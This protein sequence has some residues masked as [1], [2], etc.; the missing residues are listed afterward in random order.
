M[1]IHGL[2]KNIYK[3]YAWARTQECLDAYRVKYETGVG[4]WEALRAEG[5]SVAKCAEFC[6]ISRAT[7]FRR[8][9]VLRAL[10]EGVLPPSKAPKRRNKPQWG[11]A[12]IQ[13]VLEVRRANKTYGKDKIAVILVRDKGCKISASTVGR[14]LLFL[15]KKGRI[16]RSYSA[17][18][19]RA[20]NFSK[21]HAK[22]WTYKN[23]KDLALGERVQIDHMSVTKNGVTA[24]HFQAWE[25]HSKHIF[26]QV[27]SNATARSAKRFLQELIEITPYKIISIQVDGGS[28]FMA[29]FEAA[30]ENLAIPLEV[31]P[32]SRPTYNGGVERGNRTF[33]EEFYACRDLLA[34][35]I[36][37][38][39]VELK[40]AVEKYNA[41]RPHH[42]LKGKTPF[43]YLRIIQAEVS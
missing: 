39:R 28:E 27:Y 33:R 14:I 20:R 40:K 9:Q 12:Q 38:I 6:G 22:R 32:P 16:T 29:D 26:A 4:R 25:R 21:G 24:K 37:A 3:L 18:Q 43:E 10:A 1:Q 42:A 11:E 17:P 31:L 7:Y 34:D 8:K 23:Y 5:V 30:C 15:R 2:H 35:S 41:Y 36:G 19:K 13:L